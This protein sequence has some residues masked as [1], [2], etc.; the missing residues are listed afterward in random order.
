MKK[1]WIIALYTCSLTLMCFAT[2]WATEYEDDF[3]AEF[4]A[5]KDMLAYVQSSFPY[6]FGN[7]LQAGDRA[8]AITLI[9]F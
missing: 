1:A 5:Q 2:A 3:Q 4:E 7:D 8:K 9:H 6:R